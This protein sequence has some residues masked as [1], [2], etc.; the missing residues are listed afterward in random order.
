MASFEIARYDPIALNA[1]KNTLVGTG[2]SV[3][4][5]LGLQFATRDI[6]C[7]HRTQTRRVGVITE[8]TVHSIFVK[9]EHECGSVLAAIHRCG[10]LL[11]GSV[12]ERN[13]PDFEPLKVGGG[14]D[15]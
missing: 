13:G 5:A 2:R 7:G 11:P 9:Y 15:Q 8:I 10:K 1:R 4:L 12:F 6:G 14:K 3:D